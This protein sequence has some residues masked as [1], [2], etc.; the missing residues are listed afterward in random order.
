MGPRP[1]VVY[2]SDYVQPVDRK[3]LD[4]A[5]YSLYELVR[6]VDVDYGF[7]NLSVIMRLVLD[8]KVPVQEFFDYILEILGQ[9]LPDL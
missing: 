9:S 5:S 1:P 3:P 4:Y 6:P 2:V 8:C 7:N